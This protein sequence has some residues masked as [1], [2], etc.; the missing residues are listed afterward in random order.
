MLKLELC[1]SYIV[2]KKKPCPN[3]FKTELSETSFDKN[4]QKIGDNE[5]IFRY[6]QST[7]NVETLG[8]IPLL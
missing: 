2:A 7:T 8:K 5:H 4:A 1:K 3:R 6:D